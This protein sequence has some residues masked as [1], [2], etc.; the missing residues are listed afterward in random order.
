M[1]KLKVQTVEFTN[2]E[3]LETLQNL[4]SFGFD[5]LGVVSMHEVMP[6][7]DPMLQVWYG[8]IDEGF[9]SV[10]S[11]PRYDMLKAMLDAAQ[12]K[13]EHS[14]TELGYPQMLVWFE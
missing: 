2:E 1:S 10:E 6:D 14:E 4:I 13:Y 5:G 12:V 3:K 8:G 7:S 9:E 11:H